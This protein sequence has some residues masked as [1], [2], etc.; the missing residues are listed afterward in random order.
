MAGTR[1]GEG[2]ETASVRFTLSSNRLATRSHVPL[3][4]LITSYPFPAVSTPLIP[5]ASERSGERSWNGDGTVRVRHRKSREADKT[6][7]FATLVMFHLSP[8]H[9]TLTLPLTRFIPPGGRA[10]GPAEW[11]RGMG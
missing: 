7:V 2:H 5:F 3:H 1:S 11:V 9:L 10:G 8:T 4:S 6:L